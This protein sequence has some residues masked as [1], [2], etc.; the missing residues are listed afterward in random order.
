M[1]LTTTEYDD[2][3]DVD[4]DDDDDKTTL[5]DNM[6]FLETKRNTRLETEMVLYAHF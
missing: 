2:V 3:V 1:S 4:D 5:T 6:Y